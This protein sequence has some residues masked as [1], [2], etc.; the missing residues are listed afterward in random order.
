MKKAG[1]FILFLALA[2][3]VSGCRLFR[4]EN[5][6]IEG[7]EIPQ[8]VVEKNVL[9]FS[10]E[11][12]YIYLVP[13]VDGHALNLYVS[14]FGEAKHLEYELTYKVGTQLQGAIGRFDLEGERAGP[15]E[16]LLGTC[17]KGVCKYDEGVE[18]GKIS[19]KFLYKDIR[20]EKTWETEFNLQEISWQEAKISSLDGKFIF[21]IPSGAISRSTFLVTMPL[22]GLPE[23]LGRKITGVPYSIFTPATL[24]FIEEAVVSF[25][26]FSL[27]D[28][29]E[30]LAIFGWDGEKWVEYKTTA[31]AINNKL[32]AKVDY[33]T[34]F[35][36]AKKS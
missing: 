2:L 35:V 12:P 20:E 6:P 32:T 34:S 22:V 29:F 26:F 28:D 31:D 19:V 4:R 25:L 11:N 18:S 30:N 1:F 7:E 13:R 14:R 10:E 15:E 36:V 5:K 16:I 27:P 9:E 8:S 17:S 23:R 33:L 21:N 24:R 3:A